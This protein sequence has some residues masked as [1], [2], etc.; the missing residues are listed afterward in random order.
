MTQCIICREEKDSFSDE[1]VIPDALGGYYHI[2]TVCKPCNSDLGSFVDSKLVN[3]QFAEFQRYILGL[4]GKS[5]KLPNPFSGMHHIAENEGKKIQLRLGKDGKPTPYTVT[6]VSYEDV[7]GKFGGTKIS[8]S[9][10]ATDEKKLDD[11]LAK[12]SKKLKIP[13]AQFNNIQ[14][15]VE[16]I[17]R[18]NIQCTLSIDLSEF[19]IGL[20]KIAYEFATDTI[21]EYFSDES[22]IEISNILKTANYKA[23]ESYVSIGNGFDH[24]IFDSMRN[25]IDLDSKKHYLALAST[26]QHGLQCL[27][28]LHGMFSVG[29]ILS[30]EKY[31]S[32]LAV[33]GVNDIDG[34]SFRKIYP[35]DLLSEMY[36]PPELQLQYY[37]QTEQSLQ[38]FLATQ[39]SD[40]FVFYLVD[41]MIPIFDKMG[42]QLESNLHEKMKNVESLV[43]SEV[44]AEGEI[45]HTFPLN[46][47]LF[48]KIL[49]SQQLI[50]VIAVREKWRQIAKL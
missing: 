24:A 16:S 22:A 35:K 32:D 21:P 11:I 33:I 45:A 14:R 37:F 41:N 4:K 5:K 48:I 3:H 38:E 2:Y 23:V 43:T 15:N 31:S 8:I 28:H 47:E 36:A 42:N 1:H 29:I 40:N 17:E 18:P 26:D 25:Y 49:P 6:S 34:K 46:E 12:I 20:L 27:I 7:P 30:R 9:L 39:E 44:L 13:L 19:K 10:D 50:Q